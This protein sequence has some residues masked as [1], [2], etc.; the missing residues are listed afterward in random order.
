MVSF[1]KNEGE[2]QSKIEKE[3][4]EKMENNKQACEYYLIQVFMKPVQEE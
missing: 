1:E 3:I 2:N 4:D